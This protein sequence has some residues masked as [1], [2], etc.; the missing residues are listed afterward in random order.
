MNLNIHQNYHLIFYYHF[1]FLFNIW[2][3]N[4]LFNFYQDFINIY[5][6]TYI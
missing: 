6:L 4:V 2:V 5:L 3:I 1:I